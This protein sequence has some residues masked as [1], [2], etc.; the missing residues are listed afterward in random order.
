LPYEKGAIYLHGKTG[1]AYRHA[2]G[3][4]TQEIIR[5]KKGTEQ[6]RTHIDYSFTGNTQIQTDP[7]GTI[8][9]W[10][11]H[12]VS[13]FRTNSPLTCISRKGEEVFS[14]QTLPNT[15]DAWAFGGFEKNRLYIIRPDGP[16]QIV[17]GYKFSKTITQTGNQ[18]LTGFD[19]VKLYDRYLTVFRSVGTGTRGFIQ[20]DKNIRKE[21]WNEPAS[22][23]GVEYLGKGVFA[24]M[25][26]VPGAGSTNYILR[27]FN[28]KKTVATH[29]VVM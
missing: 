19:D 16:D 1:Y 24:R 3:P 7:Y 14:N 9:Y 20:Y 15:G 22:L 28:R 25:Q 4:Y 2:T 8:L 13:P 27:I 26:I 21:T 12:G 23:G 10:Y 29:Q 11:R 17:S 18:P 6:N 5:Y